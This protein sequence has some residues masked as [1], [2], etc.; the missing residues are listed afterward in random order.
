MLWSFSALY[1]VVDI[2]KIKEGELR[3]Y[4]QVSAEPSGTLTDLKPQTSLSY[5]VW[6]AHS[7][8]KPLT[9]ENS[10]ASTPAF[11]PSRPVL[12]C[13]N[14]IALPFS[15]FLPYL[16]KT[17]SLLTLH[18]AARNDFAEYKQSAQL[19]VDPKSDVVTRV[20]MLFRGVNVSH[21][22]G[23]RK[24]DEVN[25]VSEVRVEVDEAADEGLLRM[26]EWGGMEV[27]G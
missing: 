6:E 5:L 23:C 11:D 12:D 24:P 18:I 3:V 13:S 19:E 17:L 4:W 7:E 26:L 10:R 27:L 1:P 20:F 16:V 14:G 2:S 25:W 15:S 22:E 9:L 21:G 8:P